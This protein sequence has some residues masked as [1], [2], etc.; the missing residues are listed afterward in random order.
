MASN[1]D[2]IEMRLI[3]LDQKLDQTVLDAAVRLKALE[4]VS[5]QH[6][7]DDKDFQERVGKR[8]SLVIGLVIAVA[9]AAGVSAAPAVAK[10]IGA[11]AAVL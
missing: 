6:I 9:T 2:S 1:L 11:L 5:Q 7:A 3:A 10:A 4:I 8:L